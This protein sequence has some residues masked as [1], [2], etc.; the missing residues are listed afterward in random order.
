MNRSVLLTAAI[1][2]AG[3]LIAGTWTATA[4]TV[5]SKHVTVIRF[6]ELATGIT[7]VP[8]QKLLGTTESSNNGDYE[9]FQ[10][11]LVTMKTK[12]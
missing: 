5:P 7:Y 1:V 10:D 9:A 8:V 6:R 3:V 11:P 12:A 2:A 4:H